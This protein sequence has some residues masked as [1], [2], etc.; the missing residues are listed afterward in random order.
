MSAAKLTDWF[1]EN[2]RPVRV[3]WYERDW[4][5]VHKFRERLDYW[6]GSRW[7]LGDGSMGYSDPGL[8]PRR[9]RGLAE[10]PANTKEGA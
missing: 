4:D 9:W 3:G 8:V 5:H 1:G 10:D 7:F 6:D 2:V